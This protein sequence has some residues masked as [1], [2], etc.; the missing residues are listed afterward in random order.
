[1][2]GFIHHKYFL[3]IQNCVRECCGDGVYEISTSMLQDAAMQGMILVQQMDNEG[4]L[5]IGS[6]ISC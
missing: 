1:M 4:M 2:I 6:L 3:C 5:S